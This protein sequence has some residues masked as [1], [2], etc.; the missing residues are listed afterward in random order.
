MPSTPQLPILR[1]P[2]RYNNDDVTVSF[3]SPTYT[4]GEAGG[5]ATITVTRT[6]VT[7]NPVTVDYATSNGTATGGASCTAGVDFINTFGMLTFAGNETTKTFTVTICDDN[8]SEPPP[9]G[10]TVNLTL[11]NP[12]G[13]AMLENSHRSFKY[14]R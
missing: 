14:Y 8:I 5:A 7:P 4:I 1:E 13:G 9:S 2:G 6:G 3:S 11:S 10:E 12:T